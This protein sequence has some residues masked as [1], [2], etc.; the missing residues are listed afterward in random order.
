[1]NLRFVR[2][3]TLLCLLFP[4]FANAQNTTL[5]FAPGWNLAGNSV[6]T[7]L[8]VAT[9]L[10]DSTKVSTVWKWLPATNKWAF[11]TP[12][13]IDGGAAYAA[14]K[15]YDFLVTINGGEGFW[16]NAKTNFSATLPTGTALATAYF[17]NVPPGWSLIAVGDSPTAASFNRS[18]GIT[19]LATGT[20]PLNL[21]SLWAWDYVTANWYF[22]APS[23]DLNSTLTAYVNSKNYISFGAKIL[24]PTMG[25]W[26]NFPASNVAVARLTGT[27]TLLAWNDLGM[28]CVDGKDYSVFSILPPFNNLHAQLV[29][30]TTGA[31]V[32]AASGVTLTYE[33]MADAA[34][35]INTSS[36]AKTNFW[37]WAM[38]L[39]NKLFSLFSLSN[40]AG[41]T[42]NTAPSL[43]PR[44]LA[45]NSASNWF[46]AVGIPVTPFDDSGVKNF[47]PMVKVVAKDAANNVL[48]TAR[49]VLP[50]SDE[51][52]CKSCHASNSVNA[53]KPA[54]G[55]VNDSNTE[56][57]WKKNIL[58]LHDDKQLGSNPFSA[59][60]A[61]YGYDSRGLYQTVL[62][63]KP[64]LCAN[65]HSSNA[66]P[67]TGVAGISSLTQAMHTRHAT[68]TDPTASPGTKLDDSSN[69]TACYLCHPG[70]VT[71]CLRGAMGNALAANGDMLIGCQNC[72]GKMSAVGSASRTGWLQ[73][74]NCQSCHHDGAR[75]TSALDASANPISTSDTRFA[76]NANTPAAG[77]SLYRFSTGHG[78]LQ[79]EA[80]HGA[81]HAEYPSSHVNDNVLSTDVQGHSGTIAECTSCHKTVPTTLAGGPHGMHT[82]GSA[83]VS[84]HKSY[85]RSNSA[86][87]QYCH[88]ANYRGSVLSQVKMARSFSVENKTVNFTAGHAISCYDCHNGPNG[89]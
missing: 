80:C 65:C 20:I 15:G 50:V 46:E 8:S 6:N 81:T 61:Q 62:A 52:S 44:A 69:R 63:G 73:E 28:H 7:P 58:S 54:N 89:D 72:H 17:Q 79:C 33:A 29:N 35:S 84:A 57:D 21:T 77:F 27:F 53:A 67:G 3:F 76:T 82:I 78:K 41:L 85:A 60:L 23:L 74:P 4:V 26:V 36:F 49:T 14:S 70:S 56:I 39:Y 2:F 18:L 88:G 19:P 16:V 75:L 42:G 5:N 68:V 12:T 47:Y 37:T 71:K 66:L 38:S 1:M 31:L 59:A 24:D 55:W 11:Y 32:T 64:I 40:D 34:G 45:Y 43:T 48:A 10:G 9:S 30:S 86:S 25:F 22:Y 87:C 83:W 51:M 13:Q